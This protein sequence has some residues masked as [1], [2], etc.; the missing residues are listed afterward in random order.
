MEAMKGLSPMEK[1]NHGYS[2]V[3]NEEGNVV[4][5]IRQVKE[6][7]DIYVTDGVIRAAVESVREVRYGRE[8][9]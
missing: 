7:L 3:E 6:K 8:D 4:R 9:G 5:S 1:L 2:Y